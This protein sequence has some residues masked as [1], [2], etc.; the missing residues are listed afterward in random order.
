MPGLLQASTPCTPAPSPHST[1]RNICIETNTLPPPRRRR[2]LLRKPSMLSSLSSAASSQPATAAHSHKP[3]SS[4]PPAT[5][6]RKVQRT[7]AAG[8]NGAW[9][10]SRSGRVASAWARHG[11][12]STYSAVVN[13]NCSAYSCRSGR[14]GRMGTQN[15]TLVRIN[16]RKFGTF[17]GDSGR[18]RT[19]P[20]AEII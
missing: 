3:P 15:S 18:S 4:V 13:S 6:P 12:N 5:S 19:G 8:L 11:A 2:L 1:H 14:S 17:D 10:S 7:E 16:K 9:T 20:A